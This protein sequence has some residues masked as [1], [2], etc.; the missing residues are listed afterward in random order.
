MLD[1]FANDALCPPVPTVFKMI[2]LYQCMAAT[3]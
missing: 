2:Y 1:E 3:V